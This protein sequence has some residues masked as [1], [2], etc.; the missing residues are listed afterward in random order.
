[1]LLLAVVV[2]LLFFSKSYQVNEKPVK[3][4]AKVKRFP[5]NILFGQE[6]DELI[7]EWQPE[8][9]VKANTEETYS[10][11]PIVERYSCRHYH[12]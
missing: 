5:Y 11:P 9:L 4:S 2:K 10:V 12:C 6:E 1:M 8:P 7:S 3:L